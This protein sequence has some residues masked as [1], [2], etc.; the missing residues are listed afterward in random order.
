MKNLISI[1]KQKQIEFE[2]TL[3][4]F[5]IEEMNDNDLNENGYGGYYDSGN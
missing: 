5:K 2:Q 3:K 4:D 1:I